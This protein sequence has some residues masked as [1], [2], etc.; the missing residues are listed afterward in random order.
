MNIFLCDDDCLI[1]KQLSEYLTE[2]FSNIKMNTIKIFTFNTAF[3][4]LSSSVIPDIVFLDIEMPEINGIEIAKKLYSMYHDCIIMIVTSYSEYLDAAM[5][6]HVLRYLDKPINKKRLFSSLDYAIKRL[7]DI[8][9]KITFEINSKFITLSKKD[10]VCAEA[11]LR[12][13]N[14]YTPTEMYVSKKNMLFWKE[15]LTNPCFFQP[16]RSYIVN[17]NHIISFDKTTLYTDNAALLVPIS[18]NIY[19]NFKTAYLL[20]ME[21]TR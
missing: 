20:F 3:P 4:L 18:R 8:S 10:I 5:D 16:H 13:V 6:I 17:M 1:T 7:T 11:Q 12:N 9:G 14:I 21:N 15:L 2:Y 19:Q